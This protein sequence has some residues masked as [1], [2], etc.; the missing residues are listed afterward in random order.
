MEN[1]PTEGV[2]GD[3][4]IPTSTDPSNLCPDWIAE[5]LESGAWLEL[6]EG[7]GFSTTG[8]PVPREASEAWGLDGQLVDHL[9]RLEVLAADT[10]YRLLVADGVDRYAS[11][12][13]GILDAQ[14]RNPA[15][16]LVWWLVGDRSVSVAVACRDPEGRRFVRRMETRRRQPDPVG[17]RQWMELRVDNLVAADVADSGRALRRHV[18]SVLEQEGITR[19]FFDGFRDALATLRTDMQDGPADE[20]SRHDIALATLLRLV[21]LYFLQQRGALDGDR[22]FV[23]RHYRRARADGNDFYRAVLRPLFFGALNRPPRERAPEAATLGD[24]PFLNGGLFEPLPAER[25]HPDLDWPETVWPA[26]VEGVFEQF[27]FTV[28]EGVGSDENRAVDPEM[29]GKVFEGLM[30]GEK[31]RE[32]GSFYTPRDIVRNVVVGALSGHVAEEV[33]LSEAAVERAIRTGEADWNAPQTTRLSDELDDLAVLDPAVGTGAFLLEAL[34]SIERLYEAAGADRESEARYER[35]RQIIRDNLFGVDIQQTAVRICELRLWLALLSVMPDWDI[36]EIPPLP[37]LSHRIGCGNSLFGPTDAAALEDGRTP[38]GGLGFGGRSKLEDDHRARVRETQDAFFE[39]HG[40]RK[41]ELRRQLQALEAEMQRRLL[42]ARRQQ[43]RKRL[44]P[45][46]N[47]EDSR[48][49]FGDE[50]EL[51]DAQSDTRERLEDELE[52]VDRAIEQLD[53]ER[54][55]PGGFHFQARFGPALAREGF[56]LVVTNPPW[57]RANRLA[58][59][60]RQQLKTRY[61]SFSNDLWEGADDLGIRVPFGA[62]VDVAAL[63]VERSLELLRPK[64]RLAALLPAKLF[65]SL[66]GTGFR[67][68]VAG[69]HIEVVRDYG[70]SDRQMFDATVYPSVLQVQKTES[71]AGGELRD[72]PTRATRP[73]RRPPARRAPRPRAQSFETTVWRGDDRETWTS[74]LDSVLTCGDDVGAPWMFAPP[75][76]ADIF[77][78]MRQTSRLLGGVDALQPRRGLMTGRNGVFLLD[79]VEAADWLGDRAETWTRPSLSG[80]DVRAWELDTQKR[81]LWAYDDQLELRDDL[82]PPLAD[83]FAE[84]EADLRDRADDNPEKPPW[85]LFRLKPGLLEP[86]V[87]WRDLAPRLEAALAPADVVPLNTVYFVPFSRRRH[88][89]AFVALLNSEPMRAFAYA[90]GER[91]R[92]GWRRHFA[93][94]MRLLP[95]PE[96]LVTGLDGDGSSV[97]PPDGSVSQAPLDDTQR[98]RL[99]RWAGDLFD[100]S[101]RD[102]ETLRNW[103]NHDDHH[104]EAA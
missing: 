11:I 51:T 43:L 23:L 56:D 59:S 82:P 66:H 15:E 54:E 39:A 29:L 30:Y 89:E 90:I 45:L 95:V 100:L 75:R 32:S 16:C 58:R 69:E 50:V 97:P 84:H 68:R 8:T 7:L 55:Q 65:R 61:G 104:K 27:H 19:E 3:A 35:R 88:A 79:Q 60:Q 74:D 33:D 47:L 91:A 87:V 28:D 99:D 2:A 85:Q 72:S 5:C 40:P 42:E 46:E 17:L 37:N 41:A 71:D 14:K 103:R 22:R 31:R 49:L 26:I 48:D 6:A 25:E 64:G 83:Y 36:A 52:V 98:D 62:Q 63:F 94:V 78:R 67:H 9:D 4:A 77:D 86:K 13:R 73:P 44:E 93:W 20:E 18:E 10:G 102:L 101:T 76:V 80:R 96:P 92:G 81:L 1:Q 38:P 34:R 53:R 70:D 21:F 24:L 57:I 12:R